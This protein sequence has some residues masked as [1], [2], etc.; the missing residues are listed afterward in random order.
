V[1]DCAFEVQP[2]GSEVN[3]L[4][5]KLGGLPSEPDFLGFEAERCSKK[6]KRSSFE[7]GR[8]SRKLNDAGIGNE[9]WLR[10]LCQASAEFHTC[11]FR[12]DLL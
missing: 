8:L 1:I 11:D 7:P 6:V 12:V 9:V 5:K 2:C 4:G 3:H 10:K